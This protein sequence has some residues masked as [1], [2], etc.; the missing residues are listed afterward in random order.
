MNN[1]VDHMSD[2]GTPGSVV[3]RRLTR[4]FHPV[5]EYSRSGYRFQVDLD[6]GNP[7]LQPASS[8]SAPRAMRRGKETI[9]DKFTFGTSCGMSQPAEPSLHEQRRFACKAKAASQFHGWHTV[10]APYSK[11][12]ADAVNFK[13]LQHPFVGCSFSPCLATV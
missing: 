7:C 1:C 3:L 5:A 8:S 4:H 12:A 13:D 9:L 2:G 11:N 6:H 10:S